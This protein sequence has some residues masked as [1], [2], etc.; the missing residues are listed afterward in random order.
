MVK[1]PKQIL[2]LL[3]ILILTILVYLPVLN[4]GFVNLDDNGFIY[5]NIDVV[6]GG[7]HS[8]THFFTKFYVGHYLP[9][10]MLSFKL[11]H[12]LFGLN[13]QGF[14]IVNLILHLF[15]IIL[16][17]ILMQ[18]LIREKQISLIITALFA[19]H[20][21]HVE[22]V[23]WISE[24]KDVLY[25]FFLLLSLIYYVRYI[26]DNCSRKCFYISLITFF[27]ALLS[28]SAAVIMPFLLILIDFVLKR[29]FN[30]RVVFEKI[31]F[32]AMSVFFALLTLHSQAVGGKGSEVFARFGGTDKLIFAFYAFGFYIVKIISPV[33]LSA[34]H[35]FPDIGSGNL[36]HGFYLI[37]LISVVFLALMIWLIYRSIKFKSFDP[38]L[39]G[40]LFYLFTIL[41]YIYLPVGR[42]IVAERFS[43]LSY[44][45]LFF[46]L[47]FIINRII[48][49][50]L[51]LYF[52]RSIQIILVLIILLF[53]F[54]T[55][56]RSK[57]WQ[58]GVSLWKNVL[59]EYPTDPFVNKSMAD[60][61]VMYKNYDRALDYYKKAITYDSS[62]AEAYYNMGIMNLK[63][64]HI[65]QAIV[66]FSKAVEI[67]PG[68]IFGYINRGN[69]KTQ[70]KD[71][72]GAI[73]D[74]TLAINK[75]P[76]KAEAYVNRGSA[77][78]LLNRK[79]QACYDWLIASNLGNAQAQEMLLNYCK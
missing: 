12:F 71:Y 34:Y 62:F 63:N 78:F 77:Y 44:I 15:N 60:A 65:F 47:A 17:Y 59:S 48:Q 30:K 58:N 55:Y 3:I 27:L 6:S 49:L 25:T 66:D 4:S 76:S 28:K 8:I 40:M 24:R 75:N 61:F 21:M 13:A 35:P 14:H 52:N 19:L 70:L 43:Y 2:I 64:D 37:I 57:I 51:S 22:S 23:A 7:F 33:H 74:F 72:D 32:F 10:T 67:D 26:S 68:L 9:L 18:K 54:L 20:P 41:L 45:G 29:G 50:K 31:P 53:S 56:E 36:P 11:D 42:V 79:N 5:E 46:I 1:W 39:F 16:V 69:A 38:I 73:A